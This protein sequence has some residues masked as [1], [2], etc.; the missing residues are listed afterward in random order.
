MGGIGDV[1]RLGTN[2]RMLLAARVRAGV[3]WVVVG[4]ELG[5]LGGFS[6]VSF[7]EFWQACGSPRVPKLDF[8]KF[9]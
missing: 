8:F 1:V 7:T 6:G 3:I 9:C 4:A 5:G 2:P